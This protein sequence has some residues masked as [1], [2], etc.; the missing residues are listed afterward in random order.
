LYCRKIMGRTLVLVLSTILLWQGFVVGAHAQQGGLVHGEIL[1]KFV[2]HANEAVRKALESE[3]GLVLVKHHTAIGIYHYRSDVEDIWTLI[4]NVRSSPFVYFAEPNYLRGRQS[5]PNDEFYEFQWYLPKI[6]W[7]KA[8]AAFSGT[9][10]VI[11]AVI[12]SGVTKLHKHLQG[13]RATSGEWDFVQN[14]NDASDESGHGTMVA[15]IITG[16]T[17]D[18]KSVAG[19]CPTARILPIRV[20]DNAGFIAEGP[21]VDVSVLIAALDR[22]RTHGAR[23]INLSLGGPMYSFAERSALSVCD[24]AGIL[25]VCAAGNGDAQGFGVN[26][27]TSPIYPASYDVP[28]IISVAATDENR[29]IAIFSNFGPESVDIAAPGQFIVGCD[30]PRK[31][32][33]NWDFRFGWQGW[34][35]FIVRGNG[36]VVDYYLGRLSLVTSGPWPYYAG[37]YAANSLFGLTSPR[38]NLRWQKGARLE[39][40]VIGLLGADDYLSLSTKRSDESEAK[41]GGI[42]LYPGWTYETIQRDISRLDGSICE[43]DIYLFADLFGWGTYSSGTLAIDNAMI[44]VLDQ[45]A[46]A[47][48]A[49]WY[50]D[51]TSFAAPII[52]GVAAM[53]I[54]QNPRLTHLQ[55]REKILATATRVSGLSGKVATGGVVN[56]QAALAAA[57]PSL[58][59]TD[60]Q[61]PTLAL[62][63]PLKSV[64]ATRLRSFTLRGTARDN[65]RLTRLEYRVQPPGSSY[66]KWQRGTLT[67][68]GKNRSWSQAIDLPTE[69]AWR[70]QVRVADAAGNRSAV[71]TRRFVVDRTRPVMVVSTPSRNRVSTSGSR[72]TL[73]GTASDNVTAVR[74]DFRV[75]RPGGSYGA[76]ETLSLSGS[77]AEKSWTRRVGLDARGE[78]RVQIRAADRAGNLS[79]ARTIIIN[80]R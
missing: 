54:S 50:A 3:H 48:E 38:V 14:D 23:I 75:R 8:R 70:V 6:G 67:G 27:D 66:T 10:N 13:Y 46:F 2:D 22:A 77:A 65:V 16:A 30:V 17:D 45:S 44:T 68:T 71:V 25:L 4:A 59:P 69:G 79:G 73:K 47:T 74:L 37:P 41:Y 39:L 24:S 7:E 56:A 80:R 20:F 33:Y 31:I 35:E 15:G 60:K 34:K 5:A 42:L 61:P 28:G 64:T 40:G 62:A 21:S 19:I 78:W 53:M 58:S 55:V 57:M 63:A 9:N 43:L 11:V 1:V 29:Q 76:W 72:Y 51:G 12:D 18:G 32:L 49:V 52:S 36:W 26:N